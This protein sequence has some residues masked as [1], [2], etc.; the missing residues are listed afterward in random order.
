MLPARPLR[1]L[2]VEDNPINQKLASR[3]LE[4]EGHTVV[5]VGNGKEALATLAGAPD[6]DLVLMDLHMPEMDGLEA[7][8]HIRT[9]ERGTGRRLPIV[10][11]TAQ[12]EHAER[13]RCRQAGMD[14]YVTKPAPRQVLFQAIADALAVSASPGHRA[15]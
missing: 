15:G 9:R 2:L 4:K 8:L 10:A 3:L 13:E 7:T 6:I 1:V 11:F 5:V 12:A 14:A